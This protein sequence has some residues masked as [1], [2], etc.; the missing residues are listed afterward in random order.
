MTEP[1]DFVLGVDLDG[2]CA[3]FYNGIRPLA[4]EWLNKTVEELEGVDVSFDLKEWGMPPGLYPDF[5][6]W[7]VTQ[8]DLFKIMKPMHGCSR[9]LRNLSKATV[10]IRIITHRLFIRYFHRPAVDQTVHWLD[11]HDIPYWDLCF[12]PD[13][14]KAGAHIYVEDSPAMI[15]KLLSE[16]LEVIILENSTNKEF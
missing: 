5:H 10:R 4:A 1:S 7:A 14:H 8:R 12:I 9:A 6:K 13:K 11:Y 15:H 3:D 16:G 2:V